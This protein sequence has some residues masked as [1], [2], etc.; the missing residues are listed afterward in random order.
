MMDRRTFMGVTLMALESLYGGDKTTAKAPALF[1]AHG[2]PM[3]ITS[4]NSYTE[5]MSRL[6]KKIKKPRAVLIISAHWVTNG[7]FVGTAKEQKTIYDFYGFPKELYG[8]KYPAK[9]DSALAG[10]IISSLSEFG[11]K[12]DGTRGLDHGA[13][14]VMKFLLPNHDVPMF[15]LSL[16]KNLSPAGHF[17]L[18]KRLEGLRERGVMIVGSG[19]IVHNLWEIERDRGAKTTD[20]ALSFESRIKKALIEKDYETLIN[21]LDLGEAARLSCPTSEHYLPLLYIAAMTGEEGLDFYYE[22]FEHATISL[23]SFGSL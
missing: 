9:G 3:N 22:G 15:Q 16:D 14:G 19:D 2:S 11:A 6:S 20:W 18:G 13:W 10:E 7:L 21:Y 1:C 8:I 23:T 5:A 17:R 4:K 12:A